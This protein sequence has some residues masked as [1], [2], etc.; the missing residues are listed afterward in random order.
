MPKDSKKL[1]RT[2]W[3]LYAMEEIIAGAFVCE[4]TGEIICKKLADTRGSY[5]DSIGSSYLFDMNDHDD[6]N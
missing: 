4:Y 3:G 2:F 5:Y 1:Q 6:E